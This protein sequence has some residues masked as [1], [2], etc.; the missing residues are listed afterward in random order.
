M[1]AAKGIDYVN[2]PKP[3]DND[4]SN[5]SAD[6]RGY[7][8]A[9]GV[10]NAVV[11]A[12]HKEH[13]DKEVKVHA[14]DSLDSCRAMLKAATKGKYDG[15]LLEGMACPGG[16]VAGAGTLQDIRKSQVMVEAYTKR[17][18][19][20]DATDDAFKEDLEKLVDE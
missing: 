4:F 14:E 15:Y 17:S 10:A 5:A 1:M 6:G 12:I 9:G 19:I 16:C 3:E 7:A 8:V 13:P 18:P 2:L 20:Q 11:H